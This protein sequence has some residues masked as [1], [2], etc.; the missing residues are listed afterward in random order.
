MRLAALRC[1]RGVSL[2]S[3]TELCHTVSC[4]LGQERC[5]WLAAR[6]K[7][8]RIA[9]SSILSTLPFFCVAGFVAGT[10]GECSIWSAT[11]WQPQEQPV[12]QHR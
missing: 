8:K 12:D 4:S 3:H 1:S 6:S 2:A 9:A 7:C 11:P 5:W 10:R